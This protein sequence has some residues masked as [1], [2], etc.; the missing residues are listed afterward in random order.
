MDK[1][2]QDITNLMQMMAQLTTELA[3]DREKIKEHAAKDKHKEII[4]AESSERHMPRF[5]VIPAPVKMDGTASGLANP[6]NPTF[7]EPPIYINPDPITMISGSS[8]IPT[9]SY[10]VGFS[11]HMP[12]IPESLHTHD[13]LLQKVRQLKRH[14]HAME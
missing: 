13:P 4:E 9:M 1:I 10:P 2:E 11:A 3:R 8:N 6:Q 7:L 14:F 5:A 12:Y